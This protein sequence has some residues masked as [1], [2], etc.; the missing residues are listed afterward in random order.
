MGN[1]LGIRT[2]FTFQGASFEED[3]CA[4]TRTI[5]NGKTLDVENGSLN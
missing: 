2:P 1:P 3:Q 4:A 5:M